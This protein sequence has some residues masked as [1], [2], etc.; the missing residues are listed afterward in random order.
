VV[1]KDGLAWV[2]GRTEADGVGG[3]GGERRR[4][5]RRSASGFAFGESRV[6]FLLG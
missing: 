1:D 6:I 3:H 5:R 4:V 2:K